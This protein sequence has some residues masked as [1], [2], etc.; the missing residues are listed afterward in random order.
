MTKVSSGCV[1]LP[2]W[3]SARWHGN[4]LMMT[5]LEI[6]RINSFKIV[7]PGPAGWW[8]RE[9]LPKLEKGMD[10]SPPKKNGQIFSVNFKGPALENDVNMYLDDV[11]FQSQRNYPIVWTSGW[12]NEDYTG[13]FVDAVL[14][15][16]QRNLRLS[17]PTS[18]QK[19]P[20]SLPRKT[21][22]KD[23]YS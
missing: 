13:A 1:I 15:E 3:S 2:N 4:T 14:F 22:S 6:S 23:T 9:S 11:F 8:W 17:N 16:A 12:K 7:S 10:P 5:F 20:I 19:Q 18:W 21:I